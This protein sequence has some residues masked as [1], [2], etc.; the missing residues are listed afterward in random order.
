MEKI[1]QIMKN[2]NNNKIAKNL[3]SQIWKKKG[4]T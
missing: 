2:V 1:V 3:R 4:Y